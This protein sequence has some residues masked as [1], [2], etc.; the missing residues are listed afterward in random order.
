MTY[1]KDKMKELTLEQELNKKGI[2]VTS[3]EKGNGQRLL[4]TKKG[5][6]L[7]YFHH[8]QAREKL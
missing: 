8:Y 3:K 2:I 7:G 5:I 4:V 1:K 6:E